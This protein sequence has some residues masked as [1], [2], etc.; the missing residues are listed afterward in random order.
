MF[1]LVIVEL[2]IKV[3]MI[4]KYLFDGYWV[5]VCMGYVWDFFGFVVEILFQYKKIVWVR[6]YGINIEGGFELFYVVL[7]F[8]RKVV[9][10]LWCVFKDVDVLVIVMDE[11]CEGELIGWYF[12]QV[13]KSKVLVC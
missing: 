8:K 3:R 13:L 1:I 2:S 5:E 7:V 10:E 6:E 12:I 4:S 11:D 9:I